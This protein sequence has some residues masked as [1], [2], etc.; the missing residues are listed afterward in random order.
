MKRS[1]IFSLYIGIAFLISFGILFSVLELYSTGSL[2]T[3]KNVISVGNIFE[4]NPKDVTVDIL[5]NL[6]GESKED[7]ININSLGFRGDEFFK[8]KPAGT[9]RIFML[10]GSTMFGYGATSDNTTIP[11]YF[12]DF[13][14]Q[15][16]Y[17]FEIEVINSGIQGA[18]SYKELL[19]M[20]NRLVEFSPD[21]V[22]IY[23]GWNDLRAGTHPENVFGNWN[24]M[25][26]FGKLNGFKVIIVIQ[27]LAGFGNKSLTQQE[28]AYSKNGQDYKDEPLINSFTKYESYAKNLEKLEGC[29]DKV[30]LRFVFDE[31]P[32]LIYMDQGHVLDKGNRI[33]GEAMYQKILPAIPI[34]L[35]SDGSLYNNSFKKNN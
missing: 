32:D 35:I 30:D 7:T 5:R 17:P 10:G 12:E 2:T 19:L 26:N 8:I 23:D 9:Y 3:E 16:N 13:I 27:P 21:L 31:E 15:E 11:G 25:C 33:V 29:I 28:L 34:K 24:S 6:S 4:Q 14:K 20:K 22:I 1:I 18:D